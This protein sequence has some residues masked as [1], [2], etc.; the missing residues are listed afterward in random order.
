MLNGLAADHVRRSSYFMTQSY[1]ICPSI[2]YLH[3]GA[4][5]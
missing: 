2:E 4:L 3:S 5:T 1:Y